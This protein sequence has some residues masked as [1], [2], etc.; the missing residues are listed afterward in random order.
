[1]KW[2][3][4]ALPL[5]LGGCGMFE[6]SSGGSSAPT[7]EQRVMPISAAAAEGESETV[8]ELPMLDTGGSGAVFLVNGRELGIGSGGGGRRILIPVSVVYS[9]GAYDRRVL[10]DTGAEQSVLARETFTSLNYTDSMSLTG[11]GGT[12]S[13][14]IVITSIKLG[15]LEVRNQRFAVIPLNG[16]DGIIGQDIMR[17]FVVT[18]DNVRGVVR[19]SRPRR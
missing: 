8:T 17:N 13:A 16:M 3:V 19:F 2:I 18:L 11:V 4:V 12:V 1:M 6:G 15:Q 14:P 9:N 10:L 7:P 5:S